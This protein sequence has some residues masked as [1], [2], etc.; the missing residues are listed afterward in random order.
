M[1]LCPVMLDVLGMRLTA[2]ARCGGGIRWSARLSAQ[3]RSCS[4]IP[5]FPPR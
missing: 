5:M 3:P 4:G 1:G 2:G